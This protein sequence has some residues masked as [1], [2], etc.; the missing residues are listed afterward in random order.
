MGQTNIPQVSVIIVNW[1]G[2]Y[3]LEQCLPT[4]Q[5]QT[6]N[7]FEIIIVDNGSTDG[8]DLWLQ[9]EWTE[10]RLISLPQN[11][12]FA[13][14][15]NIGIEASQSPYIATL[16]NDTLVAQDWLAQMLTAVTAPDIGMVACQMRQWQRPEQIDSAG[17]EL[18]W[19]GIGWN[20]GLNQPVAHHQVSQEVF[21]PCAGA[22]LYR[23]QMLD[24]IGYFDEDFFAYYEDVDLAW[25]AQHAGW[26][27][28]Y[29]PT[30]QVY[31]WHSATASQAMPF[32]T[33]LLGRNKVWTI[34]KNY[35]WPAIMWTW[36][37]ILGYDSVAI[38]YQCW[39]QR[40]LA[41][42]RG[43]LAGLTNAPSMWAKRS[44]PHTICPAY[45]IPVRLFWQQ[46]KSHQ[47]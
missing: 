45:M 9:T 29:Q 43:R 47:K 46:L 15:N 27:C 33:F 5:N 39:Q 32:K 11:I 38:I 7:N 24:E 35:P 10:V 26:R 23:R 16:N 31:H 17:I 8:S 13:R 21:G 3:W 2:R 40:N 20:R 6:S 4:L 42:L 25:R 28:V 12:G 22:A 30:A 36:P 18:D 19:A 37:L 34:L 41:A 1:N 44:S 14:A